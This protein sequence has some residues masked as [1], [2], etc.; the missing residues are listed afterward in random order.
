[1]LLNICSILFSQE[2][3]SI[4]ALDSFYKYRSEITEYFI[5][6]YDEEYPGEMLYYNS[7]L[8]SIFNSIIDRKII[9]NSIIDLIIEMYE[10][11][12]L[13]KVPDEDKEMYIEAGLGENGHELYTKIFS[14][15]YFMNLETRINSFSKDDQ[16]IV[17][18]GTKKLKQL[19]S[20]QDWEITFNY[21]YKKYN[22]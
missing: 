17:K 4:E 22:N 11:T 19:F 16:I 20:K 12:L 18:N 5:Y 3:I 9:S 15:M 6:Y 14:I 2:K 8:M 7:Q 10:S 1:M 13:L 21:F